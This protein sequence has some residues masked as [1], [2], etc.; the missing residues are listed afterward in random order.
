MTIRT[1]YL[2]KNFIIKLFFFFGISVSDLNKL[3]TDIGCM[4]QI[5]SLKSTESLSSLHPGPR[6][7][8]PVEQMLVSNEPLKKRPLFGERASESTVGVRSYFIDDANG[9]ILLFY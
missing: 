6:K 4:K 9:I 7:I 5:E 1:K 8:W 3:H 2:P